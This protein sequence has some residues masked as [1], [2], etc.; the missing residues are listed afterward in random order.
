MRVESAR[1]AESDE[2]RPL[3]ASMWGIRERR[4]AENK[5]RR[6]G[7]LVVEGISI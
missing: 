7:L 2:E 5:E 4:N 1:S 6:A 3:Q